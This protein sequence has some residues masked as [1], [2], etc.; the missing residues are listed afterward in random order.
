LSK[1]RHFLAFPPKALNFQGFHLYLSVVMR[2]KRQNVR[3]KSQ[4]VLN[5]LSN[6]RYKTHN[7]SNKAHNVRYKTCFVANKTHFV[8][9]KKRRFADKFPQLLLAGIEM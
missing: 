6:I 3:Y 1:N 4:N 7:V 8:S 5:N 9:Q 2:Y